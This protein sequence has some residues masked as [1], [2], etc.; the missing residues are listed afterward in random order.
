MTSNQKW[1]IYILKWKLNKNEKQTF[2]NNGSNGV[3]HVFWQYFITDEHSKTMI[4]IQLTCNTNSQKWWKMILDFRSYK[5]YCWRDIVDLLVKVRDGD[6]ES[7][8]YIYSSNRFFIRDK[9]RN[10]CCFH[11]RLLFVK[12]IT[13]TSSIHFCTKNYN[14]KKYSYLTAVVIF[15]Q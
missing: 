8:L 3:V 7:G 9:K 14:K 10:V 2:K 4:C 1:W 6:G 5:N 13:T 15:L 12:Q 11:S